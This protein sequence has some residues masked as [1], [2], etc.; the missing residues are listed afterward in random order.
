MGNANENWPWFGLLP[1]FGTTNE[2]M[3]T[4]MKSNV[5]HRQSEDEEIAH[6]Y[7]SNTK[8]WLGHDPKNIFFVNIWLCPGFGLAHLGHHHLCMQGRTKFR[9]K[10]ERKSN[11]ACMSV[12]QKICTL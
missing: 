11:E 5:T 9:G 3:V 10:G 6:Q 8:N 4:P 2:N 1:N 12:F 7:F